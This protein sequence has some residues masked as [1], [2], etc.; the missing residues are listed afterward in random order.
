MSTIK[1]SAEN[2]TLNADGANNDVIIQS[3]GSTK[4]T[5]DGQNS[6]V[7]IGTASPILPLSIKASQEQLT[8]SEGDARGGTFD[9][10]SSTGNLQ[11][12]TNG[13]NARSAPQLTLN[14]NGDIT[15]NTG[16]IVFGTGGKG[17]VLGATSNTAANTLDDYEEGVHT[18]TLT[19]GSGTAALSNNE[20]AYTKIGRQVHVSG[21]VRVGSVS[22]PDGSMQIS[23]PFTCLSGNTGLSA[24]NYRTYNVDTP[25]DGTNAVITTD[26]G[27]ALANLEWSRDGAT[28]TPDRATQNGYFLIGL[29]YITA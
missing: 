9:Y 12:A 24:G 25:N 13:A 17:I 28:S 22:N 15:A 27:S 21:Q 16:D 2:L 10:R 4:V 18:A 14:L 3:N 26:A 5:V 20:L 7:G 8:I 11:I 29:T 23:L 1:S 19:M 6:R